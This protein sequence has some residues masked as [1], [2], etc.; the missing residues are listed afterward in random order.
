MTGAQGRTG[1]QSMGFHDMEPII[2]EGEFAQKQ[3]AGLLVIPRGITCIGKMAYSNNNITS[4]ALDPAVKVIAAGA[5]WVNDI[6]GVAFHSAGKLKSIADSAFRQNKITDL[7]LPDG[8][9]EIGWSAFCENQIT[10]VAF[11]GTLEKIGASAFAG[12]RLT[13]VILPDSVKFAGSDAFKNNN[14]RHIRIPYNLRYLE[15]SALDGSQLRTVEFAAFGI[16]IDVPE[17][18]DKA[19]KGVVKFSGMRSKNGMQIMRFDRNRHREDDNYCEK[20]AVYA[21]PYS[22]GWFKFID[23]YHFE[24]FSSKEA[25]PSDG[26]R[27]FF[28]G[29]ALSMIEDI[30]DASLVEYEILQKDSDL[31][32]HW[33]RTLQQA[34]ARG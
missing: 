30:Y 10:K 17:K 4:V 3:L 11:P 22:F 34:R 12:N 16:T 33:R 13:E 31:K 1:I 6:T 26:E 18:F 32:T 27:D 8:L 7:A 24:K 15:A 2:G 23:K 20:L 21:T 14:I 5:F 19:N 29:V 9:T 28:R 25:E